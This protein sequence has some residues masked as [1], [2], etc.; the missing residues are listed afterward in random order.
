VAD[1]PGLQPER[2]ALARQRAG[3]S[4][5]LVGGVAVV[6][7]AKR[8]SPVLVAAMAV[9]AALPAAAAGYAATRRQPGKPV[10]TGRA[11]SFDHCDHEPG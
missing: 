8:G 11:G 3:I 7:A 5:V 10:S 2:T 6:A 4:G 1:D 9:L